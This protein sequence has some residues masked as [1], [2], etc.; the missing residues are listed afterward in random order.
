MLP[1][2]ETLLQLQTDDDAV[3]ALQ[4]RMNAINART[5][6][7]QKEKEGVA[8]ALTRLRES[9]AAEEKA[10]RAIQT[11]LSEHRQTQQHNTAQLDV[12]TKPKEAAAA[13]SQIEH[14]KRAIAETESELKSSEARLKDLRDRSAEREMALEEMTV[15]QAEAATTIAAERGDVEKELASA[16]A[17]RQ[18]TASKVQKNLIAQYD[19][20][21]G[22]KKARAL[23]PL[24]GNSCGNCDT[25]MPT[26]GRA[27]MAGKGGIA[28]CEGCGVLLYAETV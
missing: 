20:V 23:F 18:A 4:G 10:Q 14:A 11:R 21:R 26:Q 5:A 7:M 12:V 3:D 27:A 1:E 9:I 16:L 15:S 2:V 25:A 8:N 24:N 6:A 17:A 28:V 22:R 19:R 13:M